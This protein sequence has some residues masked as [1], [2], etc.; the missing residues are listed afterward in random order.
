MTQTENQAHKDSN[1]ILKKHDKKVI[2]NVIRDFSCLLILWFLNKE[3]L[4]GNAIINKINLFYPDKDKKITGSSRIYPTLHTL[5]DNGLINGSW[6]TRG[7]Q[8]IKY[9]EIT[10]KGHKEFLRVKMV[11][12]YY[13]NHDLKEFIKEMIFEDDEK[14][15][16]TSA[17][18]VETEKK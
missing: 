14:K 12:K 16:K 13:V 4:Y 11:F 3:K 17:L 7:R 10:D 9:Y 5:E 15:I 18:E 2:N 1:L 8:Q 6:E